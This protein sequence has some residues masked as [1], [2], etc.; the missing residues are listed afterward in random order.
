MEQRSK[1]TEELRREMEEEAR[2][3]QLL[4]FTEESIATANGIMELPS[5]KTEAS[6][7]HKRIEELREDMGKAAGNRHLIAAITEGTD[8][9]RVELLLQG[10]GTLEHA[11][12]AREDTEAR[13]RREALIAELDG[14]FEALRTDPTP[15]AIEQLFARLHREDTSDPKVE[16]IYHL[17]VDL[18]DQKE[19]RETREREMGEKSEEV[20]QVLSRIAEQ[21]SGKPATPPTPAA[22]QPAAEK[23][24]KKGR[25]G[26]KPQPTAEPAPLAAAPTSRSERVEQLE[27]AIGEIETTV[28]PSL[29]EMDQIAR[30]E[31][32][33]APTKESQ[34]AHA[35]MLMGKMKVS[36]GWEYRV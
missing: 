29:N 31:Q 8:P 10:L 16:K 35:E 24:G 22:L 32:L 4:L 19:R 2:L 15:E 30:E 9:S 13:L 27:R 3:R 34:R 1:I 23:K 25:K 7:A 11:I 20:E 26:K 17:L 33:T 6:A 14:E 18:K 5:M 36:R 12:A 28:I 21:L